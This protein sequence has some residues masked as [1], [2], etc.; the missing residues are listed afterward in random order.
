[1]LIIP[2]LIL[3]LSF[4]LLITILLKVKVGLAER[5]SL[6]YL[7]GIGSFTFF[8]FAFDLLFN[9]DYSL[10]N[11]FSLLISLCATLFAIKYKDTIEFFKNIK[12]EKKPFKWQ[13]VLFW[14]FIGIIVTYTFLVNLY[15][16]V[17]DWDALALYDFRA[18]VFMV[19]KNLVHAVLGNGYFTGY[20]PSTSLTHLFIYQIGLHIPKFVYSLFYLSFIVIFYFLIKR[21]TSD[22]KAKFFTVILLVIPEIFSHSM[23]AYTNLAYSVYLTTSVL[24]MY[25]WTKNKNISYLLLSTMLSGLSVWIRSYEP[26]W[27]V[28]LFV[29]FIFSNRNNKIGNSL[30]YMVFPMSVS[31]IWKHFM[32]VMEHTAAPIST[33]TGA[34]YINALKSISFSNTVIVLNF[35]HKFVFSTWGLVLLLIGLITTNTMIVKKK[36]KYVFLFITILF[37][38]LLFAGTLFFSITQKEWSEIPDSARR[39]SMFL[40]PLM[41]YSIALATNNEKTQIRV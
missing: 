11:T 20:P 12:F 6:S 25:E 32:S 17:Y 37:V 31:F 21:N 28:C 34:V 2:F 19:D 4:G 9:I 18:K 13:S 27:L 29:V 26:F 23:M 5:L 39:M 41:L 24:Y 7:L 30:V 35:L 36:T 22:I 33:E 40:I 38:V 16:P 10:N 8:V 14:S 15:W 3:L 1:M